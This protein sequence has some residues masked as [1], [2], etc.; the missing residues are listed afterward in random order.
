M[1]AHFNSHRNQERRH[2][3]RTLKV[4][5]VLLLSSAGAFAAQVPLTPSNVIGGSGSYGGE[6]NSGQFNALQILD[7]QSAIV[8]EPT[9]NGFWL[10]PDGGPANAYITVD[11]GAYYHLNRFDLF[12]AHNA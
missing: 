9:Q 5:A 11:L 7:D 4:A 1:A 12:N 2:M 8:T 3:S 6:F 10:N